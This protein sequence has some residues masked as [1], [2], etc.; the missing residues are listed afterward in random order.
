MTFS[1]FNSIQK[2]VGTQKNVSILLYTQK[3]ISKSLIR[4]KVET[5]DHKFQVEINEKTMGK[6]CNK[7]LRIHSTGST[8]TYHLFRQGVLKL[9]GFSIHYTL[10]N[11]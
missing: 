7:L 4:I 3:S 5:K 8:I 2:K 11:Y 6:N 1:N 9:L 10:R